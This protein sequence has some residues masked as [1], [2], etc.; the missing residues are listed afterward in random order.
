[1]RK[2]TPNDCGRWTATSM[3]QGEQVEDDP[4]RRPRPRPA[5]PPQGQPQEREPAEQQQQVERP[6]RLGPAVQSRL[7]VPA[8]DGRPELVE[9]VVGH[10]R[11]PGD[12]GERGRLV[13]VRRQRL[14]RGRGL[15]GPV[16][17]AVLGV[18]PDVR[19]PQRERT[20][21]RRRWRPGG[22]PPTSGPFDRRKRSG[23]SSRGQ[24][25]SS[26][27][28]LGS[29][30]T[31]TRSARPS[32]TIAH[33]RDRRS[34]SASLSCR[35][36]WMATRLTWCRPRIS[37]QSL[38]PVE[39]LLSL[40]PGAR[41]ERLRAGVDHDRPRVVAVQNPGQEVA[42]APRR[43]GWPRGTGRPGRRPGR[44]GGTRA[45]TG[46]RRRRR[47]IPGRDGPACRPRRSASRSRGP[48]TSQRTA[49]VVRTATATRPS[50]TRRDRASRSPKR[51]RG[52]RL[53]P[54]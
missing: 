1:M 44:S 22:R 17:L 37:H 26:A 33:S 34:R 13:R 14:D 54:R 39:G 48:R 32:S 16:P 6:Q 30:R 36:G 2:K 18:G 49:G 35:P 10:L 51:Q 4:E 24:G 52:R 40:R 43:S 19:V 8:G 41:V 45:G 9:P 38:D 50:A 11:Q 20:T 29:L 12:V 15:V 28:S 21:G 3:P 7:G 27:G 42:L 25:C 46:R 5:E 31:A 47:S 53:R 23:W